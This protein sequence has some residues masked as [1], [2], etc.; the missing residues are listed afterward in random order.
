MHETNMSNFAHAAEYDVYVA[1]FE[2]LY[3]HRFFVIKYF[4]I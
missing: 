2:C 1:K 4:M 3:V